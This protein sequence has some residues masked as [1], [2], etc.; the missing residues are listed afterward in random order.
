MTIQE[1]VGVS[2][3]ILDIPTY[4]YNNVYEATL[5]YFNNEDLATNVWIDKYCLKNN[6]NQYLELT[7]E[8]MHKRLA[9]EFARIEQ[10]YPNPLSYEEI[11]SLLTSF[12]Y[13]IPGGSI[14][15]GTGNNYSIS[16]LGNCFSGNTNIITSNGI[17]PISKLDNKHPL[18][19]SKNGQWIESTVK[20]FGIQNIVELNIHRKG[21]NKTIRTTRDHIWFAKK[22]KHSS[23][24]M[25]PTINLEPG[26]K[27][28]Y[29]FTKNYKSY[30]PSPFGVAHGFYTGDGSKY[31]ND[32]ITKRIKLCKFDSELLPYFTPYPY[33]IVSDG[34][35]INGIPN[36]FKNMPSLQENVGYL[37]G[38][39]AGYFA[40]DGCI[41]ERGSMVISSV[42]LDNLKYVKDVCAVL[43]LGTYK[44]SSQER[45]SNLT[46]TESIIYNIRL[47]S[48][49]FTEQFFIK[50][51]HRTRFNQDSKVYKWTVDSIVET[52]EVETVYCAIVPGTN[53]FTLED[54][55]YTHNCFVIGNNS[56]SYGGICTTDQ[57]LTQLFKRRCGVGH[58]IS[59]LRPDK[60]PTTNA[61]GYGT[62]PVSFMHRFSATARETAQSGRR[63]AQMI[64][65]N[66]NHPDIEQ[67]ITS[68]DDLSKITGANISVKIT[69]EFM[70]AVES[71][72]D[73]YL[74][75]ISLFNYR[76]FFKKEEKRN[77]MINA[78]QLWDKLIHQVAKTAEPGILFWDKIISESPADCYE[79]FQSISTN[80]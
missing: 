15:Y 71:K 73:D 33:T 7:P 76:L 14:L 10:K 79:D 17:Q 34:I 48:S 55:I 58:D 44:I 38:W 22:N 77:L 19:L 49:M 64:T 63:G 80:P 32:R 61:A 9:K 40:A 21:E 69:D 29:N 16:S 65:M 27:L 52:K 56:D 47:M 51:K 57:E 45:I 72:R 70:K 36:S 67:F 54:N 37:Y 35:N 6:N 75:P 28:Q 68:K 18:L 30:I 42:N 46:N 78:K 11:Y 25:Y 26:Y 12:R 53:T 62:G 20:S 4:S 5:K 39:L 74:K 66:I 60:T 41:D 3:E 23:Y 31:G 8:D 1:N 59:H 13:I 2:T 43:G 24:E 50:E